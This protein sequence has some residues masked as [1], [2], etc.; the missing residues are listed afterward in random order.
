[1][2]KNYIMT[3]KN[4]DPISYDLASNLAKIPASIFINHIFPFLTAHELFR[5][6]NVC[7]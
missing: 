6:R 5:C 4:N 2:S 3:I 1:M 7:K